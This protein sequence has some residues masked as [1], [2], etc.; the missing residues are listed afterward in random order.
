MGG[1]V[2]VADIKDILVR[3]RF[4]PAG[5]M[6]GGGLQLQQLRR[7]V[8]DPRRGWKEEGKASGEQWVVRVRDNVVRKDGRLH[9]RLDRPVIRGSAGQMCEVV[10]CED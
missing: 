4:G 6:R 3:G 5:A 10:G 8:H 2:V 1:A 9:G 7:G